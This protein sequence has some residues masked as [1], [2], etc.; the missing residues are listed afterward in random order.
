MCPLLEFVGAG[1]RLCKK[2]TMAIFTAMLER[3][4]PVLVVDVNGVLLNERHLLFRKD[5]HTSVEQHKALNHSDADAR[6]RIE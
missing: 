6:K 2:F 5:G 1:P 4:L 3:G